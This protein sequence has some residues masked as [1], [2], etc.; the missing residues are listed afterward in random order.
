MA[1]VRQGCV[2]VF[3]SATRRRGTER[4][5]VLAEIR[6]GASKAATALRQA[7]TGAVMAT[8]GEPPDEVVLAPAHTV[9]K[10]SS[11]KIRRSACRSLYESGGTSRPPAAVS[12]QLLRLWLGA[13]AARLRAA[14]ATARDALFGAYAG[15]LFCL[16]APPAW[17]LALA[18]RPPARAWT[19]SR[20]AARLLFALVGMQPRVQGVQRLPS[21]PAWS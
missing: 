20:A 5:V 10:T 7:I 9:P 18:L 11:G 6:P 3:G 17:L 2:A 21:G 16:L 14:A 15:A 12:R 1:G 13:A 4:L 8:V 19:F